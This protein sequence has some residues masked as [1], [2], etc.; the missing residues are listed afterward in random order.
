MSL[1]ILDIIDV[2]RMKAGEASMDKI[3]KGVLNNY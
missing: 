3:L 2:V 1:Y